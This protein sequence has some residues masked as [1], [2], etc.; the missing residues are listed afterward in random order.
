MS[1]SKL[2]ADLSDRN[3]DHYLWIIVRVPFEKALEVLKLSGLRTVATSADL[4][5]A[6]FDQSQRK[7]EAKRLNEL[8][9]RMGEYVVDIVRLQPPADE[10]DVVATLRAIGAYPLSGSD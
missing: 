2:N 8:P 5:K 4:T 6:Y 10:A 1:N 9:D 3:V 7:P